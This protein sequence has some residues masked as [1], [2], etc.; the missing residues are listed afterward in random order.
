MLTR[1]IVVVRVL[2]SPRHLGDEDVATHVEQ[3]LALALDL[4]SEGG[5][6][7]PQGCARLVEVLQVLA[8]SLL[9]VL[10]DPRLGEPVLQRLGALAVTAPVGFGLDR[11]L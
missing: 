3:L 11:R 5:L 1:A 9:E 7:A 4:L 8:R 6:L 10:L 2:S